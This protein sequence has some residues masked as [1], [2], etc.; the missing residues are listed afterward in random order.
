MSK[1]AVPVVMGILNATPD[2]F[3]AESRRFSE[4]DVA[5]RA[6]QIMEEGGGII[7]VGACSTRPGS[8]PVSEAE[9][10]A[11]LRMALP[12][13]RQVA[14][15]AVLSVDTFRPDVAR[16]VA[17]EYGATIINDVGGGSDEMLRTVAQ[18][19]STYVLM[20][21]DATLDEMKVFFR[22]RLAVLE[23]LGHQDV[24]LDPGYGFG[25]TVERNYAILARQEELLSFGLPLLAGMSR[26]RMVYEL[27][28]TTPERALA[29]TVALNMV[30]LQHGAGILRVHDVRQ[31]VETITIYKQLKKCLSA[32]E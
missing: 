4:E 11:R 6:R 29:G 12:V 3:F 1:F 23:T 25:K 8:S 18:L 5:R 9:E 20:S 21:S 32:S 30:A 27:L 14:P 7:D 17:E 15:D 28:H 13:V 22:Q 24:I 19:K 2:S 31:A 26:K 10:M 16:M